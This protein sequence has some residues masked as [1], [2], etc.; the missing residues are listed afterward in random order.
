MNTSL[1]ST[2]PEAVRRKVTAMDLINQGAFLSEF[3]RR[4]KSVILA[5]L[6]LG[7]GLHY[8]YVGKVW[9]TLPFIC[10]FGGFIVWWLIDLLRVPGMVNN[11]NNT[12]ALNILRDMQV[13][14]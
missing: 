9:L 7:G 11:Y 2:L 3:S 6:L 1:P 14:A 5:Y 13:L 8:A 12:I 4:K 10:T